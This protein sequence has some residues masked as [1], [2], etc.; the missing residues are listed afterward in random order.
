MIENH[1]LFERLAIKEINY[2]EGDKEIVE[3]DKEGHL[4]QKELLSIN[5]F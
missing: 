2:N 5:L 3:N 1:F 4:P